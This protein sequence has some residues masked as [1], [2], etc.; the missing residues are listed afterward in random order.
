M[1][2]VSLYIVFFFQFDT[3]LDFS[4]QKNRVNQ[5]RLLRCAVMQSSGVAGDWRI[6]RKG[7]LIITVW[8]VWNVNLASTPHRVIETALEVSRKEHYLLGHPI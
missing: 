3:D 4:D 2:F 6:E 7:Y 1:E 8:G 5:E